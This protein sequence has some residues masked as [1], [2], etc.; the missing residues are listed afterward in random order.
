MQSC[1]ALY[2]LRLNAPKGQRQTTGRHASSQ[3]S[4][5]EIGSGRSRKRS[6]V[7]RNSAQHPLS[8][9]AATRAAPGLQIMEKYRNYEDLHM[10][11][12]SAALHSSNRSVAPTEEDKPVQHGARQDTVAPAEARVGPG[13][14]S[15]RAE[16]RQGGDLRARSINDPV[17]R[18]P[19]SRRCSRT[20]W[21]R[22]KN[23]SSPACRADTGLSDAVLKN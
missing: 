20:V 22:S 8:S 9:A 13:R 11:R 3:S 21:K 18:P 1:R 7:A 23:S 19:S 12:R 14:D 5:P 16:H 15:N 10:Q 4:G 17:I 2:D 6:S